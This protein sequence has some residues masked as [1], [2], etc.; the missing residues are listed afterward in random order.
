[1][2]SQLRQSKDNIVAS[3]TKYI[4]N[5]FFLIYFNSKSQQSY[6]LRNLYFSWYK[7]SIYYIEFDGYFLPFQSKSSLS[8]KG[9]RQEI[10]LYFRVDKYL[11]LILFTNRNRYFDYI[12]YFNTYKYSRNISFI[13]I[14]LILIQ[15]K[16][17]IVFHY[18]VLFI[19]SLKVRLLKYLSIV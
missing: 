9:S 12:V 6:F 11:S 1:M 5:Q 2:L 10:S 16:S 7:L 15:S 14:I 8:S 3:Y 19:S 4:Q 18:V 17:I 13:K